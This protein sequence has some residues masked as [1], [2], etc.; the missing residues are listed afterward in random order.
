MYLAV[1]MTSELESRQIETLDRVIGGQTG[2]G[3]VDRCNYDEIKSWDVKKNKPNSASLE[4]SRTIDGKLKKVRS[5]PPPLKKF[6]TQRAAIETLT[7]FGEAGRARVEVARS[8]VHPSMRSV[9]RDRGTLGGNGLFC[10]VRDR[11]RVKGQTTQRSQA[12]EPK[13]QPARPGTRHTCDV[14]QGLAAVILDTTNTGPVLC[15]ATPH[16][17]L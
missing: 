13:V 5:I 17:A 12:S 4:K 8:E 3:G 1:G 14:G 16:L 7:G 10:D 11:V 6:H 9:Q 2:F 15:E